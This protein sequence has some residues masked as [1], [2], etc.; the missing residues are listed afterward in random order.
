MKTRS[1]SRV[2]DVE[3]DLGYK[4]LVVGGCSFTYNIHDL[5]SSQWP[6]YLRDLCNF[7][8][9]YDCSLP[10]A[11]NQQIATSIQ[12]ALETQAFDPKETLVIAMWSGHT[13]CGHFNNTP[14]PSFNFQ[15]NY[16]PDTW[17]NNDNPRTNP[18]LRSALSIENYLHVLN[19]KTYLTPYPH[20]F[21]DFVDYT[22]PNRSNSF[23]LTQYLPD[24]LANRYRNWFAP[25]EN[26][27]KFCVKNLLLD[28][29]DFHPGVNGHLE[30]SRQVLAPYLI[31]N[32]T[33]YDGS[34]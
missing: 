11:G 20:V 22:I 10:G 12:W 4:N 18:A 29:D 19:L 17:W 14:D 34:L 5:H 23:D 15:Y 28:E 8:E 13:R 9:V 30:W 31:K 27:Y 24:V 1:I 33:Q 25:V 16:A 6:Y 32:F 2:F 3:Q 7:D 26:I 21:L